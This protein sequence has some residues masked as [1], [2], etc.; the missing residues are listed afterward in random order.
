MDYEDNGKARYIRKEDRGAVRWMEMQSWRERERERERV[1]ILLPDNSCASASASGYNDNIVPHPKGKDSEVYFQKKR[2]WKLY[3][4]LVC[5]YGWFCLVDRLMLRRSPTHTHTHTHTHEIRVKLILSL[6]GKHPTFGTHSFDKIESQIS[7]FNICWKHFCHRLSSD[8][9]IAIFAKNFLSS[10]LNL[11]SILIILHEHTSLSMY[12][13]WG[14][15]ICTLLDSNF[16]EYSKS[17]ENKNYI[18]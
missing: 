12:T 14:A 9:L 15:M 7:M 10:I 5:V 3:E 17:Y 4:C 2:H 13:G 18:I 1:L 6:I 16:W 11:Y 8:Y